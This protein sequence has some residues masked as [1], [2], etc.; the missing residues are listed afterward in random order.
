MDKGKFKSK[1]LEFCESAI[2]FAKEFE[3]ASEIIDDLSKEEVINDKDMRESKLRKLK[4]SFAKL[5]EYAVDASTE[6]VELDDMVDDSKLKRKTKIQR[7]SFSDLKKVVKDFAEELDTTAT[8]AESAEDDTEEEKIEETNFSEVIS[9]KIKHLFVSFS[10]LK[11]TAE[12]AADSTV[13]VSE[14][15]K[16][17]EK[18]KEKEEDTAFCEMKK[19]LA[20]VSDKVSQKLE[21]NEEL[22]KFKDEFSEIE[23][24][25]E[26]T[27]EELQEKGAK[28][29][30]FCDK[31][32]SNFS[33][34]NE[35]DTM[36]N[37][38]LTKE[39]I[40]KYS[41]DVNEKIK[42]YAEVDA[43]F[44]EKI[45]E[46]T[47]IEPETEEELEE[48]ISKAEKLKEKVANFSKED[49]TEEEKDDKEAIAIDDEKIQELA[50]CVDK[51][52]DI[53]STMDVEDKEKVAEE[54]SK[55]EKRLGAFC[56]APTKENKE[57]LLKSTEEIDEIAKAAKTFSARR[58]FS[59]LKKCFSTVMES[60]SES[61]LPPTP[62][63]EDDAKIN[64]PE[65]VEDLN[66]KINEK[67]DEII[68]K[69][70][71]IK[72]DEAKNFS[73]KKLNKLK[74]LSCFSEEDIEEKLSEIEEAK[75]EIE[76]EISGQEST[77]EEEKQTVEETEK[78]ENFEES[79]EVCEKC[80][81][82]P[83]ECEKESEEEENKEETETSEVTD[84]EAANFSKK[85]APAFMGLYEKF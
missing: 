16:E 71:E 73:I 9:N 38:G 60:I 53:I 7:K 37:E 25:P 84:E 65:T 58:S 35:E 78:K 80:G 77:E 18:T 44:G 29:C 49:E 62:M 75:E 24:L 30:E 68:V 56:D 4:E 43:Q 66:K 42:K 52:E 13:E 74:R 32:M 48:K 36:K 59:K 79:T 26:A 20:E 28:L 27:D 64:P 82:A 3:K 17:D 14:S 63:S 45:A 40:K 51:M 6:A 31:I 23:S 72:S 8:I 12:D 21:E 11:E 41:D 1:S 83:C 10:E 46:I 76:K 85:N 5:S 69:A 54:F 33:T 55:F 15:I 67:V 57:E 22:K 34:N 61:N 81:K 39:E 50:G 2:N 47:A 19:K 70:E